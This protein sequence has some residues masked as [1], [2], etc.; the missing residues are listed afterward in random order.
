M[1]QLAGSFL[2]Q[3]ALP[4]HFLRSPTS[5]K[6]V[7]QLRAPGVAGVHGDEDLGR[8]AV[9]AGQGREHGSF[10]GREKALDTNTEAG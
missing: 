10:E 4:K 5:L 7:R 1:F 9:Q 3:L 2:I 8:W 6:P